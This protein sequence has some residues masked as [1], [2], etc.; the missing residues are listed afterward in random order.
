MLRSRYDAP[1]LENSESEWM[2]SRAEQTAN[3]V[4]ARTMRVATLPAAEELALPTEA[5]S[6]QL[7]VSWSQPVADGPTQ[8]KPAK[9]APQ[10]P[11]NRVGGHSFG[12]GF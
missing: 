8:K 7:P 6:N 10:K 9:P 2:S 12:N 3:E 11:N 4:D 5:A 1:E